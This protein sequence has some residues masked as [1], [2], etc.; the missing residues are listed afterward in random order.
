M[1]AFYSSSTEFYVAGDYTSEF[2]TDRRVKIDCDTDGII[3]AL[4]VSSNYSSPSTYVTI[5]ESSITSNITD[6]WLGVV[7]PGATGSL[8]NHT[9]TASEGNGG[10]ISWLDSKVD[11]TSGTLQALVSSNTTSIS[12]N[13]SYLQGQ[14]DSISTSLSTVSG[15]ADANSY[16][17]WSPVT[18][19]GNYTASAFDVVYAITDGGTFTVTFPSSPSLGDEVKI[20]DATGNFGTNS[21]TVTGTNNIRGSSDAVSL[22]SDDIIMAA[23]Y[24][25]TSHGWAYV[26]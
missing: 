14:I 20:I 11:T 25:N 26:L 17:V 12:T 21:L 6:A 8:P 23:Y 9:H 7:Q 22:S 2:T 1:L 13:A 3:Y 24:T 4:V 18:V 5:D 10:Y 19:S 15:T 16:G